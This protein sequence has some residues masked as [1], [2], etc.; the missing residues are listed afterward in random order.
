M[1]HLNNLPYHSIRD[2]LE[3]QAQLH[4]DNNAILYPDENVQYSY[5]TYKQYNNIVNHIADEISK[6][7]RLN[8]SVTIELLFNGGI[9]YLLY[10]Y[11]VLKIENVIMFPISTKNSQSALEHLFRETNT[12][13]LLTTK[14]YLPVIEL[15]QL[16]EEFYSLQVLLIDSEQFEIKNFLEKKDQ[17]SSFQKSISMNNEEV[18]QVVVILHR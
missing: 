7:I 12:K 1:E 2:A 10:E 8:D 6:T 18:N 15:I 5:L 16:E 3:Y 17:I 13:I 4:G 14:Q 11:A 9:E